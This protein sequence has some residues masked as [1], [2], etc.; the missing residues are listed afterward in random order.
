MKGKNT[1]LLVMGT[2]VVLTLVAL[3]T[4]MEG[5]GEM[6]N[7]HLNL[8]DGNELAPETVGDPEHGGEQQH[9]NAEYTEFPGTRTN[10]EPVEVGTWTSQPVESD[11]VIDGRVEF[12]IWF[13]VSESSYDADPNW[14]FYLLH[15]GE[16][17]VYC[18]LLSDESMEDIIEVTVANS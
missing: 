12:N 9:V 13:K 1:M 2:I 16:Q 15:N 6:T 17:I 14:E 18:D 3:V 5:A 10:R 4:S 11:F 8:K 7:L